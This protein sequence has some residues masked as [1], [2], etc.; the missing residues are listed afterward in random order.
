MVTVNQLQLIC[1]RIDFFNSL[2]DYL[3]GLILAQPV[4]IDFHKWFIYH[5]VLPLPFI[6]FY[7]LFEYKETQQH[8]SSVNYALGTGL[9]TSAVTL[10]GRSYGKSS[11]KEMADYRKAITK[12][13]MT[14]AAVLAVII[15]GGGKSFFSFFSKDETFVSIGAISC[16]F[17]GVITLFQTM[18]FINNGCLQAV[19]MM[20]EIMFSSIIAFSCVNLIL[21]ALLVLVFHIGIWGVWIGTLFAQAT[22][23]LLLRRYILK[24]GL[25]TGTEPVANS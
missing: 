2:I 15:I 10:I 16:L 21:V 23:A 13:G 3:Y 1:T 19:G 25:F 14:C 12:L 11:Y 9:Q 6:I 24:S 8:V 18:K 7:L 5:D 17:I 4:E 20:K 22:Q